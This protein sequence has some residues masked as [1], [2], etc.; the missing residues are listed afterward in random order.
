MYPMLAGAVVPIY[1]VEGV[2][3]TLTLDGETLVGYLQCY[4][5]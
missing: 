1:N 4:D 5:Y 3:K 2:T